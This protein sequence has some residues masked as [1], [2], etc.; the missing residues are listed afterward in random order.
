M[1]MCHKANRF[2]SLFEG[3]NRR[4][5]SRVNLSFLHYPSYL[6]NCFPSARTNMNR[7]SLPCLRALRSYRVPAAVNNNLFSSEKPLRSANLLLGAVRKL[8]S[9]P[10]F[11]IQSIRVRILS[12]PVYQLHDPLPIT[13]PNSFPFDNPDSGRLRYATYV[14]L[15]VHFLRQ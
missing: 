10:P 7:Y 3:K 13:L 14:L 4:R 12:L 1:S 9:R 11:S 5:N 6:S 8:N 2:G 15:P